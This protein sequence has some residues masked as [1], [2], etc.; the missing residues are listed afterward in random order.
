MAASDGLACRVGFQRTTT[1]LRSRPDPVPFNLRVTELFH[2]EGESWK[3]IHRHAD[4]LLS[5]PEAK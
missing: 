3:L 2:R 5:E 1:H 4:S